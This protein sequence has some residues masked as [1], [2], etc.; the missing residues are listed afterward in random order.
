MEEMNVDILPT[1]DEL[2]MEIEVEQLMLKDEMV[3]WEYEECPLEPTD[4]ELMEEYLR[5]IYFVDPELTGEEYLEQYENVERI[6]AQEMEE[7]RKN[8]NE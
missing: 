2:L 6:I 7:Y 3:D 4:D 5:S 8:K 1:L